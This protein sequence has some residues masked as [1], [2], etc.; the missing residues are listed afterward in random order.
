MDACLLKKPNVSKLYIHNMEDIFR[1]IVIHY[2]GPIK[3]WHKEC[4][5]PYKSLYYNYLRNT[6]WKNYKSQNKYTTLKD[7]FVFR[8]KSFMKLVLELLH[9]HYYSY[10]KI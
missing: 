8:S 10:I 1:P 4:K 5:N 7:V 3:P 9:V 6:F 2:S